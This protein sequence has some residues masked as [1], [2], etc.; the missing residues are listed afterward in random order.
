M[1]DIDKKKKNIERDDILKGFFKGDGDGNVE[2]EM[3]E[4]ETEIERL[5][6]N[7]EN[8]NVAEDYYAIQKEADDISSQLKGYKNRA[9]KF[10]IAIGNID[11]SLNIKPDISKAKLIKLYKEATIQLS[12][13][14]LKKITEVEQFNKKLLSNRSQRLLQDKEKFI[15][16]LEKTNMIISSLGRK[17][18]EKLQYLNAHGA[19]DEYTK[20]NKQ[21][22]D[23]EKRLDKLQKLQTTS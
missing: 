9:S 1:D 12:D 11:K 23:K 3:V 2:I 6:G 21:L 16:E 22:S 17:E 14:V 5:G 18:N 13:M 19:L 20:L 4:L 10:K 8:F 15:S 7:L